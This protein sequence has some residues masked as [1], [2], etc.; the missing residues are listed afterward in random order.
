VEEWRSDLSA[1]MDGN[2]HGPAIGVVPALV[3]S[4]LSTPHEA[5][6]TCH[7]LELPRGGAR[8]SRFRSC[9]RAAGCP[10]PD[11]PGRSCRRRAPA[12]PRPLP[13][14]PSGRNSRRWRAPRLPTSHHLGD[15]ARSCRRRGLGGSRRENTTARRLRSSSASDGKCRLKRLVPGGHG[16]GCSGCSERRP[17]PGVAGESHGR[18]R[19]TVRVLSVNACQ[20]A[21]TRTKPDALQLPISYGANCGNLVAVAPAIAL[22][23][24]RSLVQ[25]QPPQPRKP[26][27]YGA[28]PWPPCFFN[29]MVDAKSPHKS[30]V[31]VDTRTRSSNSRTIGNGY[32]SINQRTSAPRSSERLGVRKAGLTGHRQRRVNEELLSCALPG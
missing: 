28:P 31:F 9:P 5:D 29:P 20:S 6:L 32:G 17:R 25:I 8:H 4:G 1:T 22:I 30:R 15:R 13:A 7:P 23:T 19:R 10:A 2:R 3:A 12:P 24:Q 21:P 11:T 27:G 18:R 26:R 14:W 16:T